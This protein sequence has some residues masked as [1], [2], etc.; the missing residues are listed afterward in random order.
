MYLLPGT[1]P[2]TGPFA[3]GVDV[4]GGKALSYNNLLDAPPLPIARDLHGRMH[5]R[6]ACQSVRRGRGS[7]PSLPGKALAGDPV[8]AFGGVAAHRPHRCRG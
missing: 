7:M 5:D 4:R 2:A 1:D 6:Q 8:S 3:R